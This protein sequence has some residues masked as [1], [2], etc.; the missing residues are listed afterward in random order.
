MGRMRLGL[1]SLALLGMAGCAAGADGEG[2]GST[3]AQTPAQRAAQVVAPIGLPPALPAE[4]GD[5]DGPAPTAGE[6]SN[7]GDINVPAPVEEATP[8]PPGDARTGE[9]RMRD[10]RAWDRCVSRAQGQMDE[11]RPG[12][13]ILESPEEICTR[14]LGMRSRESVPYR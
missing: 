12:Q 3:Q 8:Q 4:P 10:I 6:Q 13:A 11:A 9:Q 7:P 2:A 1:I 5:T 14:A